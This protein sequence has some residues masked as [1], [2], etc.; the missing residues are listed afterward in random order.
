MKTGT[1]AIFGR[2]H[3]QEFRQLFRNMLAEYQRSGMSVVLL[4][5]TDTFGSET[6]LPFGE[7]LFFQSYPYEFSE[8]LLTRCTSMPCRFYLGAGCEGMFRTSK[9]PATLKQQTANWQ[10]V[11]EIQGLKNGGIYAKIANGSLS[12]VY[13]V[14]KSGPFGNDSARN[15]YLAEYWQ[16]Q[17]CG[18]ITEVTPKMS[19]VLMV[20]DAD[21]SPLRSISAYF[22]SLYCRFADNEFAVYINSPR[23]NEIN[24]FGFERVIVIDKLS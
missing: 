13:I 20:A 10:Y 7:C 8:T 21:D 6:A 11:H 17:G 1:V 5:E 9:V 19:A 3:R 2:I 23:I 15:R 14:K 22:S 4:N 12:K 16:S 24:A 18:I